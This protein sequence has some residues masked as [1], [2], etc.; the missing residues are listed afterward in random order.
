MRKFNDINKDIDIV[1][2]GFWSW[3]GSLIKSMFTDDTSNETK[4]YTKKGLQNIENINKKFSKP[5]MKLLKNVAG[6]N[7]KKFI[8][9]VN[10]EIDILKKD[11]S[12]KDE[13]IIKLK[14]TIYSIAIRICNDAKKNGSVKILKEEFDKLA[15]ENV[16]LAKALSKE[17]SDTKV[18][19]TGEE[20]KEDKKKSENEKNKKD[21]T[22]NKAVKELDGNEDQILKNVEKTKA[23]VDGD[24][25]MKFVKK[26]I[27]EQSI[28]NEDTALSLSL[29][30][31]GND[32]VEKSKHSNVKTFVENIIAKITK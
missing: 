5:C 8:D 22:N 18:E 29:I 21:D 1:N 9:D 10:K 26:Y 7:P 15:K 27:E 14:L 24:A 13:D 30:R 11:K 25:S 2:E 23:D 17:I 3:L 4:D 6:K 31:L 28:T 32:M 20:N 12:L 19:K 16:D